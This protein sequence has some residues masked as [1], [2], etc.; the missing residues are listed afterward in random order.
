VTIGDVLQAYGVDPGRVTP[1]RG[2]PVK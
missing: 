1:M 2:T